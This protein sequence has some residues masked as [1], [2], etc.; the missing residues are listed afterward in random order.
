MAKMYPHAETCPRFKYPGGGLMQRQR[1]V[2]GGELR[3]PAMLDANGGE[4]LIIIKDGTST[5]VTLGHGTGIESFVRDY[6]KYGTHS[7]SMEIVIHPY[8][9]NLKDGA[10]STPGD[11]GSV[12]GDANTS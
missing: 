9:H 10:F 1:I 7:T 12:I 3:R 2:K 11:S 8:S 5:S 4:C 6:N